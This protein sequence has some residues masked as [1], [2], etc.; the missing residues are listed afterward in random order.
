M[1][2]LTKAK[3]GPEHPSTLISMNNLALAYLSAG[4]ADI[5]LPLLD[6]YITAKRKQ[7]KENGPI[8]AILLVQYSSELLKYKQGTARLRNTCGKA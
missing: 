1:L 3:L 8:F 5:A 7:A 6:K 2:K 4:K